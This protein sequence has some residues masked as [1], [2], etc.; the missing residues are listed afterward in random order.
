MNVVKKA[1]AAQYIEDMLAT[2]G[3]LK[4]F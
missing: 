2:A 3:Q 4:A 1:L